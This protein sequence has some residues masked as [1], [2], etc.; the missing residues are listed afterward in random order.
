MVIEYTPHAAQMEIHKA[1]GFRFRTVCTGRRFGKT[2]CMAA[3]LLDRGG[4][5]PLSPAER[6]LAESAAQGVGCGEAGRV[7]DYAWIAPTYGVAE[8]GV[9]AFRMIA[10]EFARI[11]GRMPSRAEFEGAAG[12]CRVWFFI[13]RA[14]GIWCRG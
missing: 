1:R 9:E 8:R 10:P 3:E 11:V 5:D 14:S 2:L 12:K 6:A 7:R 13:S 4:G